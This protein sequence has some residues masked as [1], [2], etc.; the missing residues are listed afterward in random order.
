[1]IK[2]KLHLEDLPEK[3]T[4]AMLKT[5]YNEQLFETFVSCSSNLDQ[6]NEFLNIDPTTIYRYKGKDKFL[7]LYLVKKISKFLKNKNIENFSMK[8]IEKK[9]ISLK[10]KQENKLLIRNC[11]LI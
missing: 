3:T 11:H 6:V 8:D 2:K 10:T 5:D 9:V 7:S 1:M 4:F